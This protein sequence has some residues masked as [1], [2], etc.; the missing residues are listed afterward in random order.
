M[1]WGETESKEIK[2]VARSE[3][4]L[5]A[6]DQ[7]GKE[8]NKDK[9]RAHASSDHV[10]WNIRI[11]LDFPHRRQQLFAGLNDEAFWAAGPPNYSI[12]PLL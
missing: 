11:S 4:T 3:W 9:V 6:T 8:P 1:N 12:T 5:F 10:D 7:N 2:V